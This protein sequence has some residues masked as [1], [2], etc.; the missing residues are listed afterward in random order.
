MHLFNKDKVILV[1]G[2]AIAG[3]LLFVFSH[4]LPF[5]QKRPENIIVTNEPQNSVTEE[6][7]TSSTGLQPGVTK[8]IKPEEIIQTWNGPN[9]LRATYLVKD[10]FHTPEDLYEARQ[11]IVRIKDSQGKETEIINELPENASLGGSSFKKAI[12]SPLGN[13]ITLNQQHWEGSVNR[14]F[15]L[16]IGKQVSPTEGNY[17]EGSDW[18]YWNSDESKLVVI[19]STNSIDGSVAQVS[20]SATGKYSDQKVLL[21]EERLASFSAIS[22]VTVNGSILTAILEHFDEK[23]NRN[24][25]L[26]MGDGSYIVTPALG[27]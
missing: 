13:F 20:Y 15:D 19:R 9:G 11:V 18:P 24:F 14:T 26:D 2:L 27:N 5:G 10:Q 1:M 21:S 25:T 7:A 12:F 4:S 23:Q 22:N 17:I 16:R 8:E 3:M 6:S